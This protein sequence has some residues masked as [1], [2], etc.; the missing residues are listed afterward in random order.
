M[1]TLNKDASEEYKKWV[2]ACTNMA[3]FRLLGNTFK[4]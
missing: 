2:N 4:V 3:G 1:K